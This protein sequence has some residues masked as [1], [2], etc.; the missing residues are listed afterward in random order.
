MSKN[1]VWHLDLGLPASRTLGHKCLLFPSLLSVVSQTEAPRRRLIF[2]RDQ[3][4][5][6]AGE[7]SWAEETLGAGGRNPKSEPWACQDLKVEQEDAGVTE[8]RRRKLERTQRQSCCG[9]EAVVQNMETPPAAS[10]SAGMELIATVLE[11]RCEDQTPGSAMRTYRGR[12]RAGGSPPT[13]DQEA[14]AQG[15]IQP[16]QSECVLSFPRCTMGCP[17]GQA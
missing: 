1:L 7:V 14:G 5:E 9:A 11:A 6:G 8:A 12:E 3:P 16:R 13:R 2:G 15:S 4:L 10:G 17:L